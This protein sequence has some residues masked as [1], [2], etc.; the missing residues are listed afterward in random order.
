MEVYANAKSAGKKPT[1]ARLLRCEAGGTAAAQAKCSS[2]A[3]V[4]GFPRQAATGV[5][6]NE[7]NNR[8]FHIKC[9]AT[10]CL[11]ALRSNLRVRLGCSVASFVDCLQSLFVL[12]SSQVAL[13]KHAH[14]ARD[15]APE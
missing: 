11:A 6:A 10:A 8:P 1:D 4:L 9:D 15:A 7:V 3:V 12:L 13:Y 14:L 2:P 5:P